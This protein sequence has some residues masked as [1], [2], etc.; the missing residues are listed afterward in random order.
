M[1][2]S[3]LER[4]GVLGRVVQLPDD[5]ETVRRVPPLQ[6]GIQPGCRPEIRQSNLDAQVVDAM[7]QDVDGPPFVDLPGQ[8]LDEPPLREVR[9]PAVPPDQF[10]P[11]VRLRRPDEREQLGRVQSDSGVVVRR[12]AEGIAAGRDERFD[13]R[14]LD[15]MEIGRASCRERV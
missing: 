2:S 15:E 1:C 3:D 13:D 5:G 14:V 11:G 6:I 12:K 10:L 4:A 7:P 9:V 8:P